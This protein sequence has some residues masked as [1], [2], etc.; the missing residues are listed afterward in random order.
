MIP[1]SAWVIASKLLAT[2][3]RKRALSFENAISM[4]V[5]VRRMGRQEEKPR[6]RRPDQLFGFLA[7]VEADIVEDDNITGRQCRRKL[8]IDPCFEDTAVEGRIDNPWR[9][10]AMAAQSR[11]ES[12]SSPVAEGA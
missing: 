4:G 10:Q 2:R 7:F 5:Q 6:V 3:F 11:D 1:S 8:C 9:G 12:L